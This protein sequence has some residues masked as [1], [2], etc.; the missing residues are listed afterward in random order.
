M[1]KI[2]DFVPGVVWAGMLAL[3]ILTATVNQVRI[4]SL[5]AE[6]STYKAQVAE[7]TRKAESEARAKEQKLQRD[8][9]RIADEAAKKQVVLDGRVAA[10]IRSA[11]ELRDTI[12][13]LNSRPAPADPSI[14]AI[15]REAST[16]R[17]LLG[18][19]SEEYRSVAQGADELR[20]QV[21]G[22][23]QYVASVCKN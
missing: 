8:V 22:L 5:K 11:V 17:Q 1:W 15:A 7:N 3:A 23:Q 4:K 14:A 19:C 10:A 13:Q 18:A 21:T 16:A 6:F 2:F 20:D 12:G 9:E